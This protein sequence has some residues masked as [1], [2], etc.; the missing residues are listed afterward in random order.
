MSGQL[1]LQPL[2]QAAGLPAWGLHH[3]APHRGQV[4]PAAGL[5]GGA[6]KCLLE[7]QTK[8]KQRFAKRPSAGVLNVKALLGAFNQEKILVGA[9][10]VIANLHVD[11]RFKL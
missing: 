9:F 2:L 3:V 7:L 1:P 11:L 4:P 10:S 6:H 5:A 8:V